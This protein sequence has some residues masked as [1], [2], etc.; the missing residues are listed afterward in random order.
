MHQSLQEWTYR[1]GQVT[2]RSQ[3]WPACWA[4]RCPAA[5]P[6]SRP[7]LQRAA[8][9]KTDA[10]TTPHFYT[11]SWP[12]SVPAPLILHHYNSIYLPPYSKWASATDCRE[13][14]NFARQTS[15]WWD[16]TTELHSFTERAAALPAPNTPTSLQ[17]FTFSS[18]VSIEYTSC[19]ASAVK[20][21]VHV[22]TKLHYPATKI[23]CAE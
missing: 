7:C 14:C 6:P 3:S 21:A 12:A 22:D 2:E 13:N 19:Y 8:P 15:P 1:W 10:S 17:I 4:A 20:S 11:Q 23:F 18:L 16:F 9:H 5:A